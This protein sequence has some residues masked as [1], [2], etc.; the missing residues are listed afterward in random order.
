VVRISKFVVRHRLI[1]SIVWLALLL[2]GG[3]SASKLSNKLSYDFSFPNTASDTANNAILAHYGNGAG[4]YPVVPVV[5]L[6][7]GSSV[8]DPAVKAE[9]ARAYQSAVVDPRMRVVS[10][11][12]TGDQRFVGT[13]GRT[14][15]GLVFLPPHSGMSGPDYGPAITTAMTQALPAGSVV[16]VTGLD[17]LAAK[18][19]GGSGVGVLAESVIG[20]L[21]A[22]AVLAFVFG[23]LLAFLPLVIAVVAIMSTFF[24]V[25]ILTT[26]MSVSFVVQFLVALI[27]LGVAIDYSLLIVT[28]WREERAHGYDG[29]EAVHRAMAT[30]G[31]AV[32]FSAFTVA[33]GLV[34]LVFLPVP[35]LRSTGLGGMLISLISMLVAIT[36]LPVLLTKVGPRLEWPRL[37]KE[38]TASRAWTAWGRGVIRTRWASAVVALAILGVLGGAALTMKLGDAKS[39]ALEQ[40]APAEPTAGL[41]AL[42]HAGIPTGVLTPMDILV[43]AG[44]DPATVAATVG[45]VSGIDTVVAPT[46]GAWRHGGTA[47][48]SALPVDES[49][50]PPGQHTIDQVRSALAS[51][52]AV[53]IGG[54]GPKIIDSSHTLYGSF[55]LMLALV[56]VI[57]FIL[58]A[59]AFRSLLLPLKAVLLNLLSLGA[60]LG[61]M[62]L[63]WQDGHGSATIWNIPATGA[64]VLWIPL[65]VFAFLYGLSMDYEVFILSRMREEYDAT[66]STDTAIVQGI[67]RTGRLVTNA[68]LVL[69]L[70]A[71]SLSTAPTADVKI[72]ATGLGVGILLDATVVRALLAPALVSLFGR[73][74]WYL[75][76]WA[77]KVL[78]VEP[79]PLVAASS[80]PEAS[81]LVKQG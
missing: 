41:L 77:A 22:L 7:Q 42:Q 53:E 20:G 54:A 72:L 23:S 78:R 49:S 39:T 16:H 3:T 69:F 79:S 36:L 67:G 56:G 18:T 21:G 30:A 81:V 13:D 64:I 71:L 28:R 66:G 26:M 34:A 31:R 12:S 1:V 11:A 46:D 51:E 4:Q 75:P 63:I 62:V 24:A 68:A 33:I 73:W 9:L 61:V 15:F 19:S 32:V 50:T 14:T 29:E 37:R 52:P 80:D 55:P 65:M 70:A 5:V 10:Y 25:Y 40:S 48:V 60:T 76:V 74:N 58:L 6:P 57:S 38:G 44:T 8:T 47:M 2:A 27:G 35:F 45:A 17:E 43:P 59:R